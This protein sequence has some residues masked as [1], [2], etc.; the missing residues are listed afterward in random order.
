MQLC[1]KVAIITGASKGIGAAMAQTFVD[2]GAS[3]VVGA[4]NSAQLERVAEKLRS[5]GGQVVAIAGDVADEGYANE[6]VNVAHLQF[7][8]LDI[9]VNNAGVL[10]DMTEAAAIS[11]QNWRR[12]MDVNLNGAFWGARAQIPAILNA[13]GGSIIFTSSFV[14]HT[15]GFPAMAAYAASK[16]GLIGL[17]QALAVEYG[18][19]GLR[20]NALLPGGTKTEMAGDFFTN[21]DFEEVIAG[22]HALR[23]M[24]EPVEIA[25][26][27]LFLASDAASFVTGAAML[28]DG[29]NSI[30]KA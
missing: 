15:M 29:G 8:R 20:V 11:S 16:A 23:R 13:G 17:T 4:R 9:G 21:P 7:G 12:T 18:P 26:A 6:L 10:G 22:Y 24:A 27:A 14:G 30:V 2:A 1:G 25:N 3:V 19:Q 5:T 28:A